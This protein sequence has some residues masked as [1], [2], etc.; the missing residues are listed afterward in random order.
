MATL[1]RTARSWIGTIVFLIVTPGTV[2]GLIPALITGWRMPSAWGPPIA[3]A[4]GAGAL[5]IAGIL[6]LLDSFARFAIAMGTPAPVA[7]T[8]HLVVVGPYRFVR[9]P[10]YL[11]VVAIILGQALLFGSWAVVVYAVIV[12]IAVAAFVYSYEQPTLERTFGDEYREYKK[13][14]RAWVPRLTPWRPPAD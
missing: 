12:M 10:M 11:A 3:A 9:N 2:A 7:P 6:V 8:E 14:V 13:H 4:I 1:S 5:I